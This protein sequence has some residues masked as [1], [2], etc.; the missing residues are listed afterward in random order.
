MRDMRLASYSQSSTLDAIWLLF[1][2]RSCCSVPRDSVE[3]GD[4]KHSS[5]G[6]GSAVFASETL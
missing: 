1:G 6:P 2:A 3:L 4:E 5:M